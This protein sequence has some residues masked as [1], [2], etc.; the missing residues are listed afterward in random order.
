M[1]AVANPGPSRHFNRGQ[2][3]AHLL[4][5]IKVAIFLLLSSKFDNLII[6]KVLICR[7]TSE[8][9]FDEFAKQ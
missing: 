3:R 9:V 8:K 1:Q 7:T 6:R 2:L 5:A 4:H